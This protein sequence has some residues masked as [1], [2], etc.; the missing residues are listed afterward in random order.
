MVIPSDKTKTS[1]QSIKDWAKDDRPREKLFKQGEN[2]LCDSEL[3]AIIIRTGR[4]GE[5]ALDLSRRILQRFKTFRNMSHVDLRD[6]KSFKGLGTAK[7]AQIRA[8]LEIGKRLSVEKSSGK[9]ILIKSSK[10]LVNI[11]M[12]RMRDLKTETFKVVLLNSQNRVIDI[13]DLCEGSVTHANPIVREIYHKALQNFAAGIICVHNHPSGDATPSLED[14]VFT[15]D[16]EKASVTIGVRLVDH[17][18][19]GDD[20]FY[21]FA[22]EGLLQKRRSN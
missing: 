17:V 19:F 18:I 8:A 20:S 6:W 1:I 4:K 22:D 5:T 10:D 15:T 11:F 21:S 14:K 2:N 16:L 7:I 12:T 13:L 9:K 3:L